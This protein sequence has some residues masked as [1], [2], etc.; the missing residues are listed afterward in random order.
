MSATAATQEMAPMPRPLRQQLLHLQQQRQ[1][2]QQQWQQQQ[3]QQQQNYHIGASACSAPQD[4]AGSGGGDCV[5]P[6]KP[7][8]LPGGSHGG[9]TNSGDSGGTP[10]GGDP[11]RALQATEPASSGEAPT[12]D[13]AQF[14]LGVS[15]GTGGPSGLPQAQER[16]LDMTA[17]SAPRISEATTS[18]SELGGLLPSRRYSAAAAA[19]TEA[20]TA[21]APM[22]RPAEMPESSAD[23][24]VRERLANW[25]R[26]PADRGGDDGGGTASNIGGG[27]AGCGGR[28]VASDGG[29]DASSIVAGARAGTACSASS[30]GFTP[31]EWA[32]DLQARE[33]QL[34]AREGRVREAELQVREAEL[35]AR[36]A[37]V[38]GRERL[39]HAGRVGDSSPKGS[40]T[41][42]G[43]DRSNVTK[44]MADGGSSVG[45]VDTRRANAGAMSP[46]SRSPPQQLTRLSV[47]PGGGSWFG[48][49]ATGPPSMRGTLRGAAA[50]RT[51]SPPAWVYSSGSSTG[52]GA[53]LR[54]EVGGS[55]VH[56][57]AAYASPFA[58]QLKRPVARGSS[59][60]APPLLP[61][62]PRDSPILSVI[63]QTP[64]IY[65][66]NSSSSNGLGRP[67]SIS[68]MSAALP[69][70]RSSPVQAANAAGETSPRALELTLPAASP[71]AAA[72]WQPSSPNGSIAMTRSYAAA[73]ATSA[74][75]LGSLHLPPPPQPQAG[76]PVTKIPATRTG[77]LS[78]GHRVIDRLSLSPRSPEQITGSTRR[79]SPGRVQLVSTTGRSSALS[80]NVRRI[81]PAGRP[82]MQS[83]R[84]TLLAGAAAPAPPAFAMRTAAAS[85][86]RAAAASATAQP[87]S[88]SSRARSPPPIGQGFLS[89]YMV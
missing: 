70:C 13:P 69:S 33:E 56:R 60:A 85:S 35:Q 52:G 76:Q 38:H 73:R 3:Q 15:G 67:P 75:P 79:L 1:H 83:S 2:W 61:Q 64:F 20:A 12:R 22:A 42:I 45:A 37:A 54:V 14:R 62:V 71:V 29:D 16:S 59:P 25:P 36:E 27:G 58:P 80:P 74:N 6:T 82:A 66:C 48:N 50:A 84:T 31:E 8:V 41:P 65:G 88:P 26:E 49:P 78:P 57:T 11:R 53:L 24:E 32:R 9:A 89:R 39:L 68:A 55:A 47:R 18:V 87:G 86:G 63:N 17:A 46:L 30:F 4:G 23:G 7:W 81:A 5:P 44:K 40:D 43:S 51:L 21:V 72:T 77:C 28:G 19:A 10:S 34:R